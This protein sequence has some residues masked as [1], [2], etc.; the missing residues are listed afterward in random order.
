MLLEI[1]SN[2]GNLSEGLVVN[3]DHPKKQSLTD[4]YDYKVMIDMYTAIGN[5]QQR[6]IN[7][8]PPNPNQ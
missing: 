8:Q 6:R 5:G 1:V 3:L 7:M 2:L 4:L